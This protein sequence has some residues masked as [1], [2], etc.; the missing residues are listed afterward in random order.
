MRQIFFLFLLFCWLPPAFSQL[1]NEQAQLAD[2]KKTLM[3]AASDTAK[4][5]AL[6]GISARFAAIAGEKP[7]FLDSAALYTSRAEKLSESRRFTDGIARSWLS[8][9]AI[10]HQKNETKLSD[11]YAG[12]VVDLYRGEKNNI[13][14]AAGYVQLGDNL[15]DGEKMSV[16]KIADY[17]NAMEIYTKLDY[18]RA[19]AAVLI[20]LG[21]VYLM[22]GQYQTMIDLLNNAR[23]LYA[24]LAYPEKEMDL[25]WLYERFEYAYLG[26]DN[27]TEAL[28][29]ALASVRIIERYKDVS[30]KAFRIYNNVALLNSLLKRYDTQTYFLNKALP[31]ARKYEALNNDS[32]MVAQ[33]LGNMVVTKIAQGKPA[34]AIAYLR[35]I[36]DRYPHHNLGWRHFIYTN[37]LQAYTES[38]Q[39]NNASRYYQLVV[40][41]TE[42]LDRFHAHQT[43]NYNALIKYLTATRQYD[44]AY[45]YLALNDTACR[46]NS[47]LDLLAK[48]YLD[49]FHV[50]SLKGDYKTAIRHF[51]LSKVISDSLVNTKKASQLADLHLAYQTDKKDEDI[52]LKAQK[53][54]LLNKQA[55]YQH[56]SLL[57]EK[58]IR[59]VAFAGLAMLLLLLGVSYNRYRLKQRTNIQLEAQQNNIN[60]A[61]GT[62]R[63]LNDSLQ[64]LLREKEWLLKEIHHRVKNNLQIVISLL[65]TQSAY[66][67]NQ[68]A[69]DAIRNSQHRMHAMSLIHQK[70][71][72]SDNMAS[73]DMA[74][75]IRELVEYL[76]ESFKQEKKINMNLDVVPVKLDVSQA[77][78]LGLILN[79][80]ISNSIKY[81]FK[82]T[83]K[84]RI[85]ITMHPVGDNQYML[86]IADNGAGLPEGFD[87]YNTSS[88]GMSLMQGLSQQLEGD[89]LL[90]NK[91][92]L[93]VCITFKA[94]ELIT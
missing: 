86:C 19:K 76:D 45:R 71:Y 3:T 82:K 9:A 79:E 37:Y 52:R 22:G 42:E 14:L 50:D 18:K 6:L 47:Q 21:N 65:N 55:Q 84:G 1:V 29:Y 33:V 49:W 80:A 34:E 94:M 46:K 69:L 62:L 88:L 53:I 11:G 32:T 35:K 40:K 8:H 30:L 87:L 16:Q 72:Q 23:V 68:D 31:I 78:P 67:E 85:D 26:K 73:I 70:L 41:Q 59:H 43:T 15:P 48:N 51:Q 24:S 60:E 77:V 4:V 92:G 54:L 2:A 10:F 75:Y 13:N 74:V 38:H 61:N 25:E 64:T 81:A 57:H 7:V 27:Y 83:Q 90:E 91:N 44:M 89:F 58:T 39:F 56:I 5:S 12:K 93:R 66:L 20:K 63:D 36:G 17:K 28:K